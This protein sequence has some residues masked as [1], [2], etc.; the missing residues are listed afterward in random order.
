M[1]S[2]KER[3]VG[4]YGNTTYWEYS[5]NL[6]QVS[7]HFCVLIKSSYTNLSPIKANCV[8]RCPSLWLHQKMFKKRLV[9]HR[10]SSS[11]PALCLLDCINN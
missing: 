7:P 5:S 1:F 4:F 3:I 11:I 6:G 10:Y 2:W 9:G 8:L